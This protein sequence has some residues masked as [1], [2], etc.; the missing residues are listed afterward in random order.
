M[1]DA[2]PYIHSFFLLVN[3]YFH[4]FPFRLQVL[5][6]VLKSWSMADP[7]CLVSTFQI[8]THSRLLPKHLRITSTSKTSVGPFLYF[9][10]HLMVW[11]AST[12]IPRKDLKPENPLGGVVIGPFFR[13]S[14]L[15][16]Q[17]SPAKELLLTPHLFISQKVCVYW[18]HSQALRLSSLWCHF[19]LNTH[20]YF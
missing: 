16:S 18:V 11:H 2:L 7:I 3:L 17:R 13:G 15:P 6:Y 12:I 14:C 5:P 20:L 4:Q 19:R 1:Q 9:Q 10:F 8:L